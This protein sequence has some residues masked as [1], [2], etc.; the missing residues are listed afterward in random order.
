MPWCWRSE[1][2]YLVAGIL[3][4]TKR[5]ACFVVFVYCLLR[6]LQVGVG[7]EYDATNAVSAVLSLICSVCESPDSAL[8]INN[9][10][11]TRLLSLSFLFSPRPHAHLG[12]HSGGHSGE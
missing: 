8:K 7:G 11:L 4:V 1:L 2:D 9:P 12:L 10:S 6:L 3:D 5:L